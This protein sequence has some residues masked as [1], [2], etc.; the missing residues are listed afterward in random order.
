MQLTMVRIK[1][2]KVHVTMVTM[3]T[4]AHSH[5]SCFKKQ[6]RKKRLFMSCSIWGKR[7]A[8]VA[9]C[10]INVCIC[11]LLASTLYQILS[12]YWPGY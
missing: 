1:K 4:A 9:I 5:I 11:I 2:I 8:M 7:S 12:L 10:G 6:S 3:K